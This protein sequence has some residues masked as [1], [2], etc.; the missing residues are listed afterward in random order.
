MSSVEDKLSVCY[1]DAHIDPVLQTLGSSEETFVLT[2]DTKCVTAESPSRAGTTGIGDRRI[3][4]HVCSTKCAG[5]CTGPFCYCEA[6]D[7]ASANT[8]CLP[9]SLCREAC[10]AL[11]DCSGIQ[12]HDE[13]PH[14]ELLF[15]DEACVLNS[16]DV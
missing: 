6:V 4:E 13:H 9:A 1:C 10:E 11:D 7:E 2:D 5:G 14:C 3:A 8:L 15:H 16:L 12:V